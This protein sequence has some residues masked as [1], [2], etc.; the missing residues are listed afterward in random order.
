MEVNIGD[1]RTE[2]LIRFTYEEACS[3]VYV[4]LNA[5]AKFRAD[6]RDSKNRHC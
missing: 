1:S 2:F 4:L 5:L 6:L 3:H